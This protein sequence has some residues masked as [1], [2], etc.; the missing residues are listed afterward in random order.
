MHHVLPQRNLPLIFLHAHPE[1]VSY[2]HLAIG[3]TGTKKV[4]VRKD[5]KEA[6][7]TLYAIPKGTQASLLPVSYTHLDVYKRQ[8]LCNHMGNAC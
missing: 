8:Y 7:K 6:A 4:N 2:T 1:S 3:I 5:P